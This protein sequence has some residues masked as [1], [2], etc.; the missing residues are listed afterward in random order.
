MHF[1]IVADSTV[2]LHGDHFSQTPGGVRALLINESK[3]SFKEHA[4]NRLLGHLNAQAFILIESDASTFTQLIEVQI[5]EDN[6]SQECLDEYVRRLNATVE[7]PN[8]ILAVSG[9]RY[10]PVP[11][12]R[13]HIGPR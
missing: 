3:I 7:K 4:Y 9:Q 8:T 10:Y 6:K 5:R 13:F 12:P 1:A 11:N 2:E